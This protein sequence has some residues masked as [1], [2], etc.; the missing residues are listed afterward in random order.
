MEE[1]KKE[2]RYLVIKREELDHVLDSVV[3]IQS[4]EVFNSIIKVLEMYRVSLGKEP[5]DCVIAKK[6]TPEYDY[7]WSSIERKWQE[8]QDRIEFQRNVESVKVGFD[9]DIPF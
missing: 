2:D 6:G 5:L 3:T 1:F 9:P 8:D 7:T 4:K